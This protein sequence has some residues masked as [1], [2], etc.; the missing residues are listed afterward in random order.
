MT[1]G[2]WIGSR[3]KKTGKFLSRISLVVR[4]LV[5]LDT[6]YQSNNIVVALASV[7]LD[8]ETSGVASLI[9]ELSSKSD[10]RET[11]KGRCLLARA[12]KEVRLGHVGHVC[13]G[14]EVSK[15]SRAARVNH[16]L[17]VLRAVESL[18]LLHEEDIRHQWNAANVLAVCWVGEWVA[19]VVGEVG[20]I[21]FSLAAGDLARDF[22]D[23]CQ[24]LVLIRSTL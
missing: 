13:S 2:P 7:K 6:T 24:L 3:Q 18:L 17:E 16:S 19:L 8:S 4:Y 20:R 10:G 22:G 5:P 9:G 1:S 21:V 15:C 12:L 23:D 14:L 11:N